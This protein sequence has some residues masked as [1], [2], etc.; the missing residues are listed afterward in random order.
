[1]HTESV[2]PAGRLGK[3]VTLAQATAGRRRW[4]ATSVAPRSVPC[5]CLRRSC[6][7]DQQWWLSWPTTVTVRQWAPTDTGWH[8][9]HDRMH[10]QSATVGTGGHHAIPHLASLGMITHHHCVESM[11]AKPFKKLGSLGTYT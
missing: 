10:R 11:N 5:H 4:S 1:M 2:G 6:D 7:T 9:W 8:R 3:R